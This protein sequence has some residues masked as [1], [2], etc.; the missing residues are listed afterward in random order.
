MSLR[1]ALLG[2]LASEGSANGYT[3]AKSFSGSVS[4][5]WKASHSQIYPELARM[6]GAGLIE[7][8][9]EQQPRGAK[10]YA[11]TAEGR[12][13]LE[14]WLMEVEPNRSIRNEIALRSFLLSNLSRDKALILIEREIEYY[15]ERTEKLKE[16]RTMLD[17]SPGQ[18]FGHLSAELGLR[19]S[20]AIYGWAKW[21][22]SEVEKQENTGTESSEQ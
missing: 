9:E 8:N 16:L 10:Y 11:I 5:V 6:A 3:L 12:A 19:I 15:Q 1:M 22:R 4:H 2:L 20:E 21:A 18:K 14:R 17:N 13:E 7:I